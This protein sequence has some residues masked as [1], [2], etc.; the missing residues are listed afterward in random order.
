M[1]FRDT[2]PRR[3]DRLVADVLTEG[4]KQFPLNPQLVPAVAEG[5]LRN[6][7]AANAYYNCWASA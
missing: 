3:A 2:P 6:G 5:G 4:L 7:S 1:S